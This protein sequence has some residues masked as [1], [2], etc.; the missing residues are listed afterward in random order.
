[1]EYSSGQLSLVFRKNTAA[2]DLEFQVESAAQLEGPASWS[3]AV[4]ANEIIATAGAVQ[5]IRATLAIPPNEPR[6]F[7]RL[8]IKR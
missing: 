6:R 3:P 8:R 1:M 5:T 7:L 4:T 2:T